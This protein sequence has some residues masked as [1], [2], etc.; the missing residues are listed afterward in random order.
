MSTDNFCK[1]FCPPFVRQFSHFLNFS[2]SLVVHFG[3]KTVSK[4][5]L[6]STKHTDVYIHNGAICLIY[7]PP[8][9]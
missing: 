1:L 4:T 6:Y 5:Q 8:S 2:S 3:N 7:V 9:N